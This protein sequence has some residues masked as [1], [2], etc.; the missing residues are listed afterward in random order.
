MSSIY[1]YTCIHTHIYICIYVYNMYI[2]DPPHTCGPIACS[3]LLCARPYCVPGPTAHPAPLRNPS[4][5]VPA[6]TAFSVPLSTHCVT[7]PHRIPAAPQRT[8]APPPA[9]RFRLVAGTPQAFLGFFCTS[10]TRPCF[11]MIVV[12]K[13]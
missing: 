8:A 3:A 2:K 7:T 1:I 10:T 13:R 9:I 4:H 6:P 12:I 5:C 11:K